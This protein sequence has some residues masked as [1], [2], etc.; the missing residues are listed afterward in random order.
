MLAAA[1][2]SLISVSALISRAFLFPRAAAGRFSKHE[3][4]T[5]AVAV[6]VAVR[7]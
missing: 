7:L 2:V 1:A 4:K 3:V 6:A 5:L